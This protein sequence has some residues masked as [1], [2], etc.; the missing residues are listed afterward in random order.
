MLDPL[1]EALLNH[2]LVNFGID[3]VRSTKAER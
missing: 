3:G 1:L 2:C